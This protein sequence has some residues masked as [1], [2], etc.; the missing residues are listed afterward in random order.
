MKCDDK[1]HEKAI[2]TNC[3]SC[4]CEEAITIGQEFERERIINLLIEL[5]AIRRDALGE[6]VAFN[7]DGTKVIYLEGLEG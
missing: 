7:A 5:K 2:K 1:N 4:A 6:L 3:L